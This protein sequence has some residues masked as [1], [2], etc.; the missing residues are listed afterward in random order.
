MQG[1]TNYSLKKILFSGV[2]RR[3][4]P[5]EKRKDS[6]KLFCKYSVLIK[7]IR[8]NSGYGVIR[9]CIMLLDKFLL[10]LCIFM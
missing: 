6:R 1:Y 8:E 2:D 7:K 10:L 3:H 4:L 5:D 9:Y